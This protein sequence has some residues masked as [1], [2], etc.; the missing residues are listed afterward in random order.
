MKNVAAAVAFLI[1]G[2]A[3]GQPANKQGNRENA[4]HNPEQIAAVQSK[5]LTLALDLTDKQQKAVYDLVL[6]ESKARK[7]KPTRED[8]KEMSKEQ[9]TALQTARLDYMIAHK[10]NMKSI[11]TTEQYVKWEDMIAKKMANIKE[12]TNDKRANQPRRRG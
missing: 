2:I 7:D 3:L 5:K 4:N 10:R 6:Q 11:L 1:A 12:K 9:K 8:I